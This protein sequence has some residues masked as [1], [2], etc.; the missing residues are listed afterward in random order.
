MLREN[1]MFPQAVGNEQV[2]LTAALTR[3]RETAPQLPLGI[4]FGDV[5]D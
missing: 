1:Q 4:I 2:F 3:Q 5:K